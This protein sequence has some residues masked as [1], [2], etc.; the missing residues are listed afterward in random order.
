MRACA[1]PQRNLY[2]RSLSE[3]ADSCGIGQ[4]GQK[5]LARGLAQLF[6]DLYVSLRS[7]KERKKK[8][9]LKMRLQEGSA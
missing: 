3:T 5:S 1:F 4:F 7:A 8:R 9:K 2:T 6:I